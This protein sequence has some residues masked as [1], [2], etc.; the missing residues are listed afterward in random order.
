VI[1]VRIVV[2][3]VV[4]ILGGLIG[5]WAVSGDRRYLGY[6]WRVLKIALIALAVFLVLLALERLLPIL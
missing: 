5:A 6:A 2:L 4:L 3:V 1:V